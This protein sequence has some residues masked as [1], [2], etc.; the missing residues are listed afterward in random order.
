MSD[1]TQTP[2]R[3]SL[4][5]FIVQLLASGAV[6]SK[7]IG[8]LQQCQESGRSS[9]DAAPIPEVAHEFVRD[10]IRGPMGAFS[11]SLDEEQ[12][13][14]YGRLLWAEQRIGETRYAHG[15][16]DAEV[17]AA[18]DEA[19]AGLSPFEAGHDLYIAALT[20][21]VTALGGR[22]ELHA[23]FPEQTVVIAPGEPGATG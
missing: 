6:L 5:A 12:V 22:L 18:I 19:E 1:N 13:S 20:R 8:H 7:M 4:D 16:T 11:L 14:L 3:Q 23:V 10:V 21:Y 17:L 2:R 9:P 15:A